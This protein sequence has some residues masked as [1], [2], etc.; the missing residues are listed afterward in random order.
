ML[1]RHS[2]RRRAKVPVH[3]NNYLV[4]TQV[5][6]GLR[7]DWQK[8]QLTFDGKAGIFANFV[9]QH[10]SNLNFSGVISGAPSDFFAIGNRQAITTVAGVPDFSAAGTYH[11]TPNFELRAGY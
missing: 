10:V 7:R 2:L 4:S 11:L 6:R 3:S 9:Q 1:I 5:G 8:L